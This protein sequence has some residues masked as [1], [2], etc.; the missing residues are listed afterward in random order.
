MYPLSGVAGR[1][2]RTAVV[3]APASSKTTTAGSSVADAT[4]P[5]APSPQGGSEPRAVYGTSHRSSAPDLGSRTPRL[6]TP[7]CHQVTTSRPSDRKPYVDCPKT[8]S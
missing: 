5:T 1:L 8:Q 3:T 4:T 7:S 6:A 2:R